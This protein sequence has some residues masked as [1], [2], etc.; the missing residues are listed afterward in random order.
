VSRLDPRRW[1]L[2]VAIVCAAAGAAFLATSLFSR[3]YAPVEA[4]MVFEASRIQHGFP[5]YVDPA[6][7]AWEMGPPPSRYYVLYTPLWPWLLAMASPH[8]LDGI[9]VVGRIVSA[10]LLVLTLASIVRGSHTKARGA[11]VTGALL[12]MGFA[13][14]VRETGL[15]EADVPAVALSA[16][17]LLR[18]SRRGRLDAVSA[19]LL[20]ATPLVKPSVLGG[21]LG[22]FAAHLVLHLHRGNGVRRL[23]SPLVVAAAVA[24]VLVAGFHVAS[25]GVWWTHV[26]RATGQTLSLERWVKEFGSRGVFLGLPHAVVCAVAARRRAGPFATLPLAA[27]IVWSS[28]SM[29]KHGSGTNYWLEP[30]MAAL[31]ALGCSPRRELPDGPEHEPWLAWAGAALSAGAACVS[32]PAFLS[33][34]DADRA[35]AETT[36]AVRSRCPLRPGE[37][38]VSS[39]VGLELAIDGRVV[40]PD[41]QNAYLVRAGKFPL[42]AWRADL[43]SPAG[44]RW[45]VARSDFE[46]PAPERIEG[47]T[48]VSAYRRELHDVVA[49]HFVYRESI[50][51][52]LV[53]ER[54]DT[55]A[56]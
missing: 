53:F 47:P 50:G 26:V 22:A 37:V 23:A 12:V 29:A 9:R 33:I 52:V 25:H 45:F 18:A 38:L 8:S 35:W 5:L 39:F 27:S 55:G 54:R 56:E 13:M 32:L 48:E 20:I 41:W 11:V 17:G 15:A 34:R 43:A 19:T 49:A 2:G 21:A 14:L 3:P 16:A 30:S 10:A 46:D 6:V 44:A 51:N 1:A 24:G 31:I 7:G 4:E 40:V 42:D 28:F 36:E